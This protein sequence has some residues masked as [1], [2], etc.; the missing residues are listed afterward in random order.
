[1]H[2]PSFRSPTPPFA[3]P[4]P[5]SWGGGGGGFRSPP[6]CPRPPSPRDGYGSPHQTPP[7]G[8]RARPRAPASGSPASAPGY[9]GPPPGFS[10]GPP[11]RPL[12]WDGDPQPLLL[13]WCTNRRTWGMLLLS[14]T[15]P[16][17]LVSLAIIRSGKIT[18][19]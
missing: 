8:P 17:C 15:W 10:P 9:S 13:E 3:G 6:G 2:R 16:L 18:L 7:F 19:N 4:G 11:P 12:Q 1:M 5:G 14:V